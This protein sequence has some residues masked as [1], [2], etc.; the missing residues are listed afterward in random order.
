VRLFSG[1]LKEAAKTGEE[2]QAASI[3][4]LFHPEGIVSFSFFVASLDR[5]A[6]ITLLT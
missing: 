5:Q 3:P 4:S 1:R 2:R 6:G